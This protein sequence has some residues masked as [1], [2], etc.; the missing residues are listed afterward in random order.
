M[1][2]KN[3]SIFRLPARL[4]RLGEGGVGVRQRGIE[5]HV[6]GRTAATIPV[7]VV[8]PS[9]KYDE[10]A[11]RAGVLLILNLDAHCP[12]HDIE[13]LIYVMEVQTVRG[14]A[15]DRRFYA[16]DPAGLRA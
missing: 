10:R 7:A 8:H 11:G 16:I 12:T 5:G 3:C 6:H 9:R 2:P 14:A 15:A 4:Y 13:N 1:Q